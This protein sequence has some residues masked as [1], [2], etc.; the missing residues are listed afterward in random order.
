MPYVSEDTYHPLRDYPVEHYRCGAKAGDRVRLRRAI[1]VHPVGQIWSV[2][3][4]A[5]KHGIA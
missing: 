5:A 3:R 4:G 1:G 2:L